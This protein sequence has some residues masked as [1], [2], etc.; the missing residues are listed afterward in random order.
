MGWLT[1]RRPPPADLPDEE[2]MDLVRRGG[3]GDALAELMRRWTPP[4][5]D[6]CT[7]LTGRGHLGD[8]LAQE[9][10][11]RV[12]LHRDRYDPARRFSTWIWRIAI[13]LC[14]DTRRRDIRRGESPLEEDASAPAFAA[15]E[16][17]PDQAALGSER[18]ALVRLALSELSELHR[19]VLVLREYEGLKLR[20]IAE[21]LDVP[22]GTVKS[23]L[24]EALS[25]LAARLKSLEPEF[26]PV[27]PERPA[28]PGTPP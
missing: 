8:E 3:D 11:V 1:P 7:R 10:F 5:R 13:N 27:N 15:P 19:T 17:G 25:R 23:R 2:V 14:H 4:L 24:A 18:A 28:G 16:P 20:E 22:E 26:V 6:L 9:A 21:V 12:F